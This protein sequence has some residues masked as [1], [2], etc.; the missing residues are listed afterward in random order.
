MTLQ[1]AL[2][3]ADTRCEYESKDCEAMEVLAAEVRRL[4]GEG[5][6]SQ[7]RDEHG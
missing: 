2:D 7:E 5:L 4:R 3:W 6:P 1:E